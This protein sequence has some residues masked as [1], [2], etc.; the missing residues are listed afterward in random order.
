MDQR[1][2]NAWRMT[3]NERKFV[4]T[5]LSSG[6]RVDGRDLFDYRKLGIKFGSEDGSAEVHLGQTRVL[7]FVTSQLVQPYRDRPNEG[8]LSVFTEFSPM[9]DPSFEPG[10]PGDSA[11]ELGRVIDRGLRE[12]RA[13]DMESLCILSGKLV[14]AIRIDLHI[15]DN[16]GNLIDAANIAALAGLLASRRP[17]CSL[18]GENGQDVIIHPPEV[19]EPLPLIVHHLPIAVT[20]AI[21]DDESTV[22]ID[23]TYLEEEV[24]GGRITAT[25]NTNGEVCAIQKA[26][27]M[28]IPQNV[29]MHC[30][31]MAATKAGDMTSKIKEAV[32]AYN[33]ERT[34]RKIKRHPLP[35]SVGIRANIEKKQKKSQ[36]LSAGD[37]S[38]MIKETEGKVRSIGGNSHKDGSNNSIIGSS[39]SWDPYSKGVN[40][41]LLKLSLAFRESSNHLK[42]Q[43]ESQSGDDEH[44]SEAKADEVAKD[45]EEPSRT[46]NAAR[47]GVQSN[48]ER[49]LMDA[50]K[51]KHKREKK[52]I[53]QM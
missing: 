28:A 9:A 49:T 11:I 1:L 15:I 31:R 20:F 44:L 53:T 13:I 46:P 23:P 27:G 41:E 43:E 5:A 25:L 21:F 7:A 48:G 3:V 39:S 32:D 24:M 16:G 36:P 45:M 40:T 22:V 52:E 18:G 37:D 6:L 14:W 12:S 4:E 42:P 19:R 26:G 33:R 30:L 51:P 29:I 2:G 47:S 35:G 10:R 50:V 34:L 17:E 38:S 8:M